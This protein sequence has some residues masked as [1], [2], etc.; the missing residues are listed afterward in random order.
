MRAAHR[1]A[2]QPAIH[3]WDVYLATPPKGYKWDVYNA[4]PKYKWVS[5]SNPPTINIPYSA[6]YYRANGWAL[7]A[8]TGKLV[9]DSSQYTKEITESTLPIEMRAYIGVQAGTEVTDL[10]YGAY[11]NDTNKTETHWIIDDAQAKY[12]SAVDYYTKGAATG[13]SVYSAAPGAYPQ[14]GEASGL[15]Y[16]YVSYDPDYHKGEATGESV[17]SYY[18]GEYP[19]N[20][21]DAATDLWYVRR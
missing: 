20:G 6:G 7:N 17:I 21:Y 14:N 5:S 18:P 11:P 10:Y 4:N 19:T 13:E 15:W 16:V 2:G 3:K 1:G 8:D 9:M 12:S